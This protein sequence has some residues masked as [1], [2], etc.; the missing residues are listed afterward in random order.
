MI[1]TQA[2]YIAE[3]LA[4]DKAERAAGA[5]V[6]QKGGVIGEERLCPDCPLRKKPDQ[7]E[8]FLTLGYS[9]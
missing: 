7:R 1:Q 5:E 6:T 8:R 4:N 9:R 2:E 3:L